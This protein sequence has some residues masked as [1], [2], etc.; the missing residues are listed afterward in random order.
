[1]KAAA[2][3][4]FLVV[5]EPVQAH[6]TINGFTPDWMLEPSVTGP[7]ALTLAV[8]CIGAVRLKRR[9]RLRPW[10]VLAFG[11]G[12]LALAGTLT[13]PLHA[14][15]RELFSAHMVEHELLMTVAAPLLVASRPLGVMLW[16]LP[17]RWRRALGAATKARAW[18]ASW[19]A[20]TAILTV[21][22]L[23]AAAIWAWHIPALFRAALCSEWIHWLQHLSFLSTAL[24]F[25]WAL[26]YGRKRWRGY[27]GAVS[28]LFV[29]SMHTGLLGA[30]LFASSRLVYQR[31]DG[32]RT[33]DW[34]IS[35]LEDQQI[36]GA[37]MWT[38]A[39][40][41]YLVA[42]LAL[43]AVWIKHSG[44]HLGVEHAAS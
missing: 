5:A 11:V 18:S 20:M 42:A 7:L 36:A 1:M 10:R 31:G 4:L 21:T 37:I 41:A 27:G 15:G 28:S 44:S 16:G 35:A 30:L 25:W 29:T 8:Y 22:I 3:M 34:S 13:S 33:W 19:A 17:K 39:S 38:P 2:A 9:A 43:T 40:I 32:H 24:L 23:H 12:W 6:D 26:L 14:L